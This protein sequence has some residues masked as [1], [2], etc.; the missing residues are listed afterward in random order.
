MGSFAVFCLAEVRVGWLWGQGQGKQW[1]GY[2]QEGRDNL[3]E[4]SLN[5]QAVQLRANTD[6][7]AVSYFI[8]QPASCV[9]PFLLSVLD[10]GS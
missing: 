7:K 9:A 10:A 6:V 3:T 5:L 8:S 2:K 4:P 1:K